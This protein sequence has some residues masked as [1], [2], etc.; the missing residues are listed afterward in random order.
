MPARRQQQP[1]DG[2][3]HSKVSLTESESRV[4][5]DQRA[6]AKRV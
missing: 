2:K 6:I 1:Q 5:H 3:P 4:Q